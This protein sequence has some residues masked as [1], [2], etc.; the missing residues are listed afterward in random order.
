MMRLVFI[1]LIWLGAFYI[2]DWRNWKKFH[3]TILFMIA[4]SFMV[5]LITYN[6]TLWD[7]TSELGGHVLNDFL[8]AIL[9]FPPTL[10]IYFTHYPINK[11]VSRKLFYITIWAILF[12]IVE[13]VEYFLDNINYNHDW[14]IWKSLIL[15]LAMFSVLT[16]HQ[17][18]PLLAYVLFF[19]EVILLILICGISIG[20][21]K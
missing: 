8:I 5:G 14:N 17:T 4:G 9:F 16:V 2:S 18:K 3:S 19:I 6:H 1:V 15:N 12:T 13:M 7:L 20:E 10:L 21:F 11:G